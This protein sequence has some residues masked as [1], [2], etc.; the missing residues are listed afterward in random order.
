MNRLALFCLYPD[1]PSTFHRFLRLSQEFQKNGWIP[2]FILFNKES[3]H[4]LEQI[5]KQQGLPNP[6]TYFFWDFAKTGDSLQLPPLQTNKIPVRIPPIHETRSESQKIMRDLNQCGVQIADEFLSVF[7]A[8]VQ[9]YGQALAVAHVLI[10]KLNPR[11]F[12]YD[13]EGVGPIHSLLYSCQAENILSVCVQHAHGTTEL[14]SHYPILAEAYVAYDPINVEHLRTCG[15]SDDNIWLT[16][17]LE[18]DLNQKYLL[19]QEERNFLLVALAPS[20]RA[21]NYNYRILS[22]I[23]PIAHLLPPLLLKAHPYCTEQDMKEISDL[24]NLHKI[25]A[26]IPD[27]KERFLESLQHAKFLLGYDS[28]TIID[29]ILLNVPTL[30]HTLFDESNEGY[31][32]EQS[33]KNIGSNFEVFEI[34]DKREIA[35]KTLEYAQSTHQIPPER[36][37]EYLAF[38][39]LNPGSCSRLVQKVESR[40]QSKGSPW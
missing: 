33:L 28:S 20:S 32:A 12:F 3:K 23:L 7:Q 22:A 1:I 10:K 14:M 35:Q 26:M 2:S 4:F 27:R 18:N 29:A 39:N 15:V 19:H 17:N 21:G 16:G 6:Q 24:C 9:N 11:A 5:A 31:S 25:N 36:R 37:Q 13:V 30:V 38:F 8:E 34:I 40:I